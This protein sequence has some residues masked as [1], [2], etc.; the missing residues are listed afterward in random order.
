[1]L[2]IA[3]K[4]YQYWANACLFLFV[5]GGD[6][7]CR[8]PPPPRPQSNNKVLS[9]QAHGPHALVRENN[10]DEDR[11]TGSNGCATHLLA[12]TTAR[13][14]LRKGFRGGRNDGR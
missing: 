1:M 2:C 14:T 9:T 3:S 6:V 11:V 4:K 10:K 5:R 8:Q 13:A 7:D 12:P